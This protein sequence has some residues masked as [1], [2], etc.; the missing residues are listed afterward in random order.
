MQIMLAISKKTSKMAGG[1]LVFGNHPF[2]G[3][4]LVQNHLEFEQIALAI[5]ANKFSKKNVAVANTGSHLAKECSQKRV[6]SG[7][8]ARTTMAI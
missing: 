4:H 5:F 7:P 3:S 1:A 6:F 2:H 8:P